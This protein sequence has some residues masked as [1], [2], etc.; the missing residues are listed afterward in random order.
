MNSMT[1][2]RTFHQPNLMILLDKIRSAITRFHNGKKSAL[3]G[4]LEPL[5]A[6]RAL[7]FLGAKYT[8]P[9]C[10]WKLRAFTHG[11]SSIKVRHLGYCP[12]CNSKAR[13]R[14][15]WLYLQQNT[16]LFSER[17]SLFHISPK[18]SLSRQF[19][20]MQRLDYVAMDIQDRA[21]INILANLT[22]TPLEAESFDAVICVHVLEHIQEDY[23]AI[24]ELYRVMK[25]GGWAIV[26]VPIH[27]DQK[28]YEDPSI[29]TT[30]GRRKAFGETSHFRFYGYDLIERLEACGF[31]VQLNLAKDIDQKT[32]E[33][34]GLKDDENIFYCRKV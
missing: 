21:N 19:T 7:L 25:P 26:S 23:R 17:L 33:K 22:A 11:G 10:G 20:R 6:L 30:E 5:L 8:C 16:N 3:G 32:V 31:Q 2:L 14:R 24:Q 34:Y 13:H 15:V 18:F 4:I 1:L 27:L 9:C 12:R 28:T 29:T